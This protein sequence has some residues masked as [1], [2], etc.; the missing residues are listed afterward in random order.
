[1]ASS[2]VAAKRHGPSTQTMSLTFMLQALLARHES[3]V[4]ESEEERRRMME[5]ID[6]LERENTELEGRNRRTVQENRE[7][8]DQL[9][10][11]NAAVK[12]SENKVQS[13]TNS[14]H[15]TE[16]ELLR[17][18]GLASRTAQLTTQLSQLEDDFTAANSA[19]AITREE[20]KTVSLRWQQAEKTIESLQLQIEKIEEDAKEEQD[21]HAEVSS[22]TNSLEFVANATQVLARV[23]RRK[24]VELELQR[25]RP[26]KPQGQENGVVSH[27]VTDILQDNANLQLGITELREML[28]RSNDE[29]ERLREHMM[30]S[31]T[32]SE[33]PDQRQSQSTNLGTE[34]GATREI[35]VHHHYHAPSQ[36]TGETKTS[37]P[38]AGRRRSKRK[39]SGSISHTPR[40]SIS[41]GRPPTPS[42]SSAIL[43]QT[44]ATVPTR[45]SQR[46]SVQSGQTG[47]TSS[48][49]LP[50]S[51]YADSIFDRVFADTATDL[52]RSSSPDSLVLSPRHGNG[53]NQFELTQRE[54]TSNFESNI[55][56]DVFQR[57]IAEASRSSAAPSNRNGKAPTRESTH[58]DHDMFPTHSIIIEEN[59]D[60]ESSQHNGTHQGQLNSNPLNTSTSTIRLTLR[61]S[62]SHESLISIHGM[63]IHTLRSRPS[64]LLLGNYVSTTAPSA[65]VATAVTDES[66]FGT[67]ATTP[68]PQNQQ[69]G[70]RSSSQ[71]YLSGIAA[72]NGRVLDRKSSRPSLPGRVGGW[73]WSK[74]GGYGASATSAENESIS[75]A[76]SSIM[77]VGLSRAVPVSSKSVSGPARTDN[78]IGTSGSS[79]API[80]TPTIVKTSAENLAVS[81]QMLLLLRSPGVNQPGPI[82]GFPPEKKLDKTPIVKGLNVEALRDGLAD[83]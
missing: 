81:P 26:W 10:A 42:S 37:R 5:T 11:L 62:A 59:E 74:W 32:T 3:H 54:S 34:L 68:T 57:P 29:V 13:L 79:T 83:D 19:V 77:N 73:V 75:S 72:Q 9:E 39:G 41:M 71:T 8:L 66:A 45:A 6:S 78:E 69:Q 49:S 47:F 61:R 21:R 15:S 17:M 76:N 65:S 24:A 36:S 14:L 43:S 23:E 51:P 48:S 63:D 70:A 40:S 82:W 30:L 44:F 55:A 18:N 38:S 60:L 53:F 4:A 27:F 52:S 2:T 7:L 33:G 56:K 35:H 58:Q 16:T 25:N 80:A 20:H 31:P 22:L 64:Q 28:Q 67:R 50:S 12:N 46:W 1:M